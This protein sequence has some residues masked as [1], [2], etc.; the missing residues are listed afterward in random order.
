L[1]LDEDKPIGREGF[2]QRIADKRFVAE[3]AVE[4]RDHC[5][6]AW[7]AAG[8]AVEFA[9][10]ALIIKRERL[11]SWPSR[12]DRR[13]LYTHDLRVLFFAA[14]LSFAD[15]PAARRSALKT[16]LDWD[17]LNEYKQQK[18]ARQVARSMVDAAFGEN[19]VVDWL[20]AQ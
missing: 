5:V 9:L 20:T 1:A 14:G 7:M 13:E 2:L 19:G 17:R 18:M 11:S 8:Y 3:L 4:N 15:V 6:E 16:T 10:K 12:A